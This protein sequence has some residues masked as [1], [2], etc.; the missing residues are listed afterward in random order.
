MSSNQSNIVEKHLYFTLSYNES[1]IH[2]FQLLIYHFQ[3]LVLQSSVV[4]AVRSLGIE[5]DRL[6]FW[7]TK[8]NYFLTISAFQSSFQNTFSQNM[9]IGHIHISGGRKKHSPKSYN[10]G[11]ITLGRLERILEFPIVDKQ[12]E[13]LWC[14][15]NQNYEFLVPLIQLS[16]LTVFLHQI[17]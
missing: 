17:K 2:H 8:P 11:Q 6:A 7:K 1:L 3:Q 14:W 15:G 12:N 16:G 4:N 5:E 9:E 13:R 10:T